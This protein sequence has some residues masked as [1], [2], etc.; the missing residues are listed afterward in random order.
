MGQEIEIRT[1]HGTCQAYL[2]LPSRPRAPAL[3]IL[4]EIYNANDWV[5]QVADSYAADG[6]VVLAP[7]IYYRYAPR[8]YLPYTPEGMQ[9]GKDLANRLEAEIDIAIEDIGAGVA[10]LRARSDVNGKVG[11]IGYC[12]GG[13]LAYLAGTRLPLDAVVIYYGVRMVDY[14]N[15][16]PRLTAPT[17]MHYGDQ[18]NHVPVEMYE[19]L[20]AAFKPMPHVAMH[21]YAGAAHGFARFGNPPHHPPSADLARS[22]TLQL[23]QVLK[24]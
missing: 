19:Q 24:T 6:F 3:V 8:Q 12:L 14:L 16:A 13:K 23:L 7:D 20:R 17:I 11:V 10:A 5:R 4:P 18:D 15:E 1:A 9:Q 2:A 22:R 21:L